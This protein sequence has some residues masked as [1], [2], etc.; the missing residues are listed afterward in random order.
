[1][2]Q[3]ADHPVCVT[4]DQPDW[5]GRDRNVD[6]PLCAYKLRGVVEPRCPE[7]GYLFTW[8]QILD[9]ALRLHPYLFEHHPECNLRSFLRTVLGGLRPGRFWTSLFPTQPSRPKRLVGYWAIAAGMLIAAALAG[10]A[11]SLIGIVSYQEMLANNQ[12]A[13][14]SMAH[15]AS[16]ID[17]PSA[18]RIIREVCTSG[19]VRETLTVAVFIPAVW[20]WLSAATFLIFRISMRYARVKPIHMLRIC[21]YS[22]DAIFWWGLV[23]LA[24]ALVPIP[25]GGLASTQFI[26]YYPVSK[27][28]AYVPVES[29][30]NLAIGLAILVM[31][32]HATW[33]MRAACK[34][35][36]QFSFP[37]GTA[38]A[39]QIICFL[40]LDC[41]L[42]L[43]VW[44]K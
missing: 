16:T 33:R 22:C 17:A 35:Y 7:C 6:C 23:I 34:H 36:L 14:Q 21:V 20:P 29:E 13:Q 32:L 38:V 26:R 40:V 5:E 41:L 3:T 39:V 18:S 44:F 42:L 10:L 31:W 27:G 19:T 43:P 12:R 15:P 25:F 4:Y 37:L 1:M 24:A 30:V 9:P 28:L 11:T 2:S 8:P